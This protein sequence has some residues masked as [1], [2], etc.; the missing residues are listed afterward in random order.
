MSKVWS[1][2]LLGRGYEPVIKSRKSNIN[3]AKIRKKFYLEYFWTASSW[4]DCRSIFDGEMM[5][6]AG[7]VYPNTT[8][9]VKKPEYRVEKLYIM[10]PNINIVLNCFVFIV[11]WCFFYCDIIFFSPFPTFFSL[12]IQNLLWNTA[13]IVIKLDLYKY[14]ILLC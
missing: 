7:K 13:L 4:P 11:L 8:L 2:R 1:Q 5:M 10:V 3:W 14:S 12:K 6:K 9:A